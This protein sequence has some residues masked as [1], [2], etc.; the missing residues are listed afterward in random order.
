MNACVEACDHKRLTWAFADDPP[1]SSP[2][3]SPQVVHITTDAWMDA[4]SPMKEWIVDDS[5]KFLLD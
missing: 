3:A 4:P 2:A 1:F 5:K